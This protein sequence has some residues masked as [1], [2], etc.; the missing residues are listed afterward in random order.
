MILSSMGLLAIISTNVAA[1]NLGPADLSISVLGDS[2]KYGYPGQWVSFTLKITNSNSNYD[3]WVNLT[4][5]GGTTHPDT[6]SNW[7]SALEKD[8]DIV[9]RYSSFTN[10][11]LDVRIGKE[12]FNSSSV[13]EHVERVYISGKYFDKG[14]ST[15]T[16]AGTL[17]QTVDIEVLQKH[18]FEFTNKVGEPDPKTPNTARQV[19]FNF[20]VNNT[21]NGEDTFTFVVENAP[22]TPFLPTTNVPAYSTKNVVLYI[23]NILKST[24]AGIH[25]VT[26]KAYSENT[27]VAERQ[28][29][30]NVK[31]NPIYNLD[32]STIEFTTKDVKPNDFVIYNFTIKNKGNDEDQVKIST[33]FIAPAP[34]WGVYVVFP[35]TPHTMPRDSESNLRLRIEA[36]QTAT[37][38]QTVQVF[39]NVSSKNKPSVYQN[40]DSIKAK[41]TQESEVEITGDDIK[42]LDAAYKASFELTIDND[43]NGQDTFEMNRLGNFPANEIWNYKF[44]P[45][46]VTLGPDGQGNDFKKV[47][48]NV[49]GPSDAK[50]GSFKLNITATS[51]NNPSIQDKHE[52]EISIGKFYNIDITRLASEKQSVYPGDT[53][54]IR[55]RGE[56]IGNYQDT[57]N[58]DVD[59]PVGAESWVSDFDPDILLDLP[60]EGIQYS[61]YNLTVDENAPQKFYIFKI[62]CYSSKDPLKKDTFDLNISVKRKYEIDLAVTTTT[63]NTN[64]GKAA[65]FQFTVI[66]K[67]TGGCNV[68][69]DSSMLP[70]HETYMSVQF[71]PATFRLMNATATKDVIVKITPSAANPL[72]PMSLTGVPIDITADIKEKEGGPE[73][74]K[75]V[76]VKINQTYGVDVYVSELYKNIEPGT[77]GWVIITVKN[78]GNGEDSFGIFPSPPVSR[79]NWNV[80]ADPTSTGLIAQDAS[81][82]IRI[83][84]TI[85]GTETVITEEITLNVTSIGD[86][87]KKSIK[88]IQIIVEETKNIKFIATD[89]RK[90]VEPGGYVLFTVE[91]ENTGTVDDIFSL[92]VVSDPPGYIDYVLI[93]TMNIKAKN[94][95]STNLNISVSDEDIDSLPNM[96]NLTIEVSNSDDTVIIQRTFTIDITAVRDVR[97]STSPLEQKGKPKETLIFNI[98]IE[99]SGTG[100]DKF[101]L[102]ILPNPPYSSW[103]V[104]KNIGDF[105]P[106][107]DPL[108][109]TYANVEVEIPA[110]QSPSP[111]YGKITILAESKENPAK[112]HTLTLTINVEQ[113]F[114]LLVTPEPKKRTVDPGKNATYQI[115]VKNDGTG[116]DTVAL[117][118][119]IT[120][121]SE[122]VSYVEFSEEDLIL[123]PGETKTVTFT[124][125]TIDEVEAG[126]LTPKIKIT[127]ES[128]ND[129][130]DNPASDFDELVVEINPTVDIELQADQIKQDVTPNL[131]G[132]KAEI[133]YT[134]IIYNRGLDGDT[135]DITE[136]NNHGYIV[137]ISPSTTNTIEPD[138]SQDISVKIIVDNNAPM[139]ILDYNTT[140]KVTSRTNKDKS[141]TITL[142]MRIKQTYGMELQVEDDTLETEDT[143]S[144][145]NRII[146]FTV[147]V[148][149]IGTG[150]DTCKLDIITGDYSTWATLSN[151][152][153]TLDSGEKQSFTVRVKVPRETAVDDYN[154]I[155]KAISRGDDDLYESTDEFDEATLT[156]S[157]T[158]FYEI[159][160]EAVDIIKTGEPSDSIEF[161]ITVIN[162]GNGRDN[163]ELARRNYDTNWIWT[164][165]QKTFSLEPIDDPNEDDRRDIKLSVTIP[166]DR[167]GKEGLYN[168]SIFVYSVNTPE[169]KVTQNNGDPLI[170]TVDVDPVYEVDLVLD[171]PTSTDDQK[172]LPGKKIN[173]RVT[174]KNKGNTL[175]TFALSFTGT[176]SGW[177]NSPENTVSIGPY[178]SQQINFTLEIPSLTEVN[179]A[180]DIEAMKYQVRLKATSEGDNDQYDELLLNPT[181]DSKYEIELVGDLDLDSQNRGT[182]TVNPNADPDY[183]SFTLTLYNRGN[184]RDDISLK[185]KGISDWTVKFKFTGTSTLSL[186]IGRSEVVTVEIYGPTDAEN[187]DY[188]VITIEA[189]SKDGKITDT[190]TIY[191]TVET[192][193]IV[194][195][196]FKVDGDTSVGSKPTFSLTVANE[197]DV[198][199]E[200]VEIKFYDRS[201]NNK[202]IHTEKIDKLNKNDQ[203]EVQFTYSIEEGEHKIEATTSWSGETIKMSKTFSSEV[204]LL[205]GDM[206]WIILVVVA[207]VVFFLALGLASANYRRGIPP[208]LRQ[209]IAMAKQGKS[210]SEIEQRRQMR[211]ENFAL[212]KKK[213]ALKDMD[214]QEDME[215]PGKKGPGKMTRIKCP[216]CDKVQNVTSTKRPIEFP[217]SNCG[218]KLV[219]KK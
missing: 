107:M 78:K 214:D 156:V 213:G 75:Q 206:F 165:S 36:P 200:D 58:F 114:K 143:I 21:G 13:A 181:V 64:P 159:K 51:K 18:Q 43:G 184:A 190:Y 161:T 177:V 56:N 68:T 99:N 66:N 84:I 209:E 215:K 179:D 62:N 201:Q 142:K 127:A 112:N 70:E 175:D 89:N 144:G 55:I 38:P 148:Q 40:I 108:E 94:R 138:K 203:I 217:C 87:A 196:A 24:E 109:T 44:E 171:S 199:A 98:S 60:P 110:K 97:L 151:S 81:K 191:A 121:D 57:F 189:E 29:G 178:K 103:A 173:Y 218:M 50:Y 37:Y 9:V 174:I 15:Y 23:N 210:F 158:Q 202:L 49:T 88:K 95:N 73:A 149:N 124:V 163:V 195:K 205:S 117:T 16:Q 17:Y 207:L 76:K 30:V 6:G 42:T 10:V 169:G 116:R 176:K 141:E 183:E 14:D 194:F 26:V 91:L 34:G 2:K 104:L 100:K 170:L 154:I 166:K 63:K 172:A 46:S 134:V 61:Y 41:V 126:K 20:T 113:V 45:P 53:L 5:T 128:Q 82:D 102:S 69:M 71:I 7:L 85:P 93:P 8:K 52:V 193:Q 83:N 139:S 27:S 182:I 86:N 32:I 185:T 153:F 140:I 168:I 111:P 65:E 147:D 12:V 204:S 137:E 130:A 79:P 1:L 92:D 188:K 119:E 11:R 157:V 47:Y 212:D 160:L 152:Y 125:V 35:S 145:N 3:A 146:T 150:D 106:L 54:S 80:K 72:A 131:R 132:N 180:E 187:G 155:I 33:G 164:L 129:T 118:H 48:F 133:I 162:R 136:T 135:F 28:A 192:A 197:G 90:E 208:E 219:L 19:Q 120:E 123:N 4:L 25:F 74:T 115:R 167:H 96:D 211:N 22:G 198:D 67:G 31:I 101:A 77:T 39:L 186:D 216:K 122:S 59:V 105:T